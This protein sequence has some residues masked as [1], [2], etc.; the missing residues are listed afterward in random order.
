VH[1]GGWN[2]PVSNGRG[3][4]APNLQVHR[5]IQ[6]TYR[7]NHIK[8]HKRRGEGPSGRRG[9]TASPTN[10]REGERSPNSLTGRPMQGGLD[11]ILKI[12]DVVRNA[13]M[14][15]NSHRLAVHKMSAE[16][17]MLLTRNIIIDKVMMGDICFGTN[18]L[19]RV[20]VTQRGSEPNHVLP[21]LR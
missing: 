12:T 3:A 1:S 19:E 4:T 13:K 7:C 16:V 9:T 6:A 18:E 2:D 15:Q 20:K 8:A 14:G 11:S 21:T 17:N 10:H 5:C